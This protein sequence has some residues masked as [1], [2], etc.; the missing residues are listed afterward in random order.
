MEKNK[1]RIKTKT[2]TDE[3]RKSEKKS[4]GQRR[5]PYGLE[6]IPGRKHLAY[7]GKQLLRSLNVTL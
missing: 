1:E 3:H 5:Q 4:Q 7:Y 2:K 6:S